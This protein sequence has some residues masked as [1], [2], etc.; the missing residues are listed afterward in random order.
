[1]AGKN[2]LYDLTLPRSLARR[3]GWPHPRARPKA[4]LFPRL[5]RS[6]IDAGKQFSAADRL[7]DE[8]GR[9]S[10]PGFHRDRDVAVAGDHD[11]GQAV[12]RLMEAPQQS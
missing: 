1:M 3:C 7:L 12:A 2:H 11:G 6:A 10:L 4:C 8:V 9:A 5:F